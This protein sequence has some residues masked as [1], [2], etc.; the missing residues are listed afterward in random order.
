MKIL[1]DNPK[2]PFLLYRKEGKKFTVL[3]TTQGSEIWT[4]GE[5]GTLHTRWVYGEEGTADQKMRATECCLQKYCACGNKID[6]G[7]T[8]PL[9]SPCNRWKSDNDRTEKAVEIEAPWAFKGPVYD[10]SR[11]QYWSSLSDFCDWVSEQLEDLVDE[12]DAAIPEWIFP[13]SVKGL[14]MLDAV[15]LLEGHLSDLQE[16]AADSLDIDGLQKVLN[17]WH[18]KQTL[19]SWY[20][21]YSRKIRVSEV[22]AED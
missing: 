8:G 4:C 19:Q 9:C 18:K 14:A 6:R 7:Y 12:H 17:A 3:M 2:P 11:E 15:D 13:C 16:D 21:D 1:V 10:E 22:M 5:C 20:P